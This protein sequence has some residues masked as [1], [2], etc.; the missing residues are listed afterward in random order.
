MMTG[1][2][3]RVSETQVVPGSAG[4]NSLLILQSLCGNREWWHLGHAF[5]LFFY[6]IPHLG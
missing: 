2:M 4:K 3:G 5:L 1:Y 6:I